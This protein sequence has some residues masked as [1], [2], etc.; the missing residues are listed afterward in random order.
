M[1]GQIVFSES[2]SQNAQNP[3]RTFVRFAGG[4]AHALRLK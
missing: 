1:Q 2:F 3:A 4:Q